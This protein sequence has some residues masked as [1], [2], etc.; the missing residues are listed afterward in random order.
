[1]RIFLNGEP[2]DCEAGANCVTLLA[3]MGLVPPDLETGQVPAGV[4]LEL[5]RKV[6][7]ARKL[8]EQ[9][10]SEGDRVEVVSFVGGG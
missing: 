3:R 1:M 10:L 7:P 5:N 2:F 8:A 6:V 4:A 9:R